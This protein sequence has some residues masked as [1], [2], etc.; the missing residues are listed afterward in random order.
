MQYKAFV[1]KIGILTDIHITKDFSFY[2]GIDEKTTFRNCL[3]KLLDHS[4]E[5]LILL[6]DLA[7]FE[8]ELESYQW[9]KRELDQ[10]KIPWGYILGNHDLA[11]TAHLGLDQ[12]P[13][14]SMDCLSWHFIFVDTSSEVLEADE[15][16]RV[17]AAATKFKKVALFMHHPPTLVGHKYA[18]QMF[19]LKN[20]EDVWKNLEQL[21]SIKHI[22]CGHYHQDIQFSKAGKTVWVTPSTNFQTDPYAN[23]LKKMTNPGFRIIEVDDEITSRAHQDL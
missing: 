14:T 5:Q 20:H 11:K 4:C 17:K 10:I 19:P 22:F 21:E 18:D 2:D 3:Q 23:E 16:A 1:K 9:I 13:L 7:A 12:K 8:G 15:F 6:G